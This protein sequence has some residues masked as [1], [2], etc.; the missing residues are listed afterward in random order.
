MACLRFFT[1]RVVILL[2]F[3]ALWSAN[4]LWVCLCISKHGK[5]NNQLFLVHRELSQSSNDWLFFLVFSCFLCWLSKGGHLFD[6]LLW[7]IFQV[8]ITHICH[9][10]INWLKGSFY[11]VIKRRDSVLIFC[12]KKTSNKK[13]WNDSCPFKFFKIHLFRQRPNKSSRQIYWQIRTGKSKQ[14]NMHWKFTRGGFENFKAEKLNWYVVEGD[15]SQFLKR[16][17]ITVFL[18]FLQRGIWLF[19]ISKCNLRLFHK[20]A[21]S[22]CGKIPIF[23]H[24]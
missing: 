1:P 17:P 2:T 6:H 15:S 18:L 14:L 12:S 8:V 9:V 20:I 10:C 7:S 11:L 4:G 19:G 16:F 23:A 5:V 24:W 13:S 21:L 3:L 22:L